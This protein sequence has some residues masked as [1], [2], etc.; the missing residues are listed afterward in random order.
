M[1]RNN[2][3]VA[4]AAAGLVAAGALLLG[5]AGAVVLAAG[6]LAGMLFERRRLGLALPR[7]SR[8]AA[9]VR[10]TVGWPAAIGAGVA[11]AAASALLA[12]GLNRSA[13]REHVGRIR[14]E[15]TP[16]GPSPRLRIRTERADHRF[17]VAG[18]SYVV[19][20]DRSQPWARDILRR[21]A[22]RGWRWITV[23]VHAR[24]LHRR[25]FNPTRLA[26]RLTTSQG[27]AYIGTFRGGTGPRSLATHGAL[28][29][30]QAARVQLGFRVHRN[31]HH[32]ALVF[33]DPTTDAQ[34]HIPLP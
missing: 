15:R 33:E 32:L 7:P 22:G 13:T 24:S 25:R 20:L 4:I 21:N 27:V 23:A 17:H 16:A 28:Q 30:G 31:A 3:R 5:A 2:A 18:V 6:L 11:L 34:L 29:P 10:R 8:L 12:L 19:A 1:S 14:A 26:Y 9:G